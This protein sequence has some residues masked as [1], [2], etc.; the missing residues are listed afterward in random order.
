MNWLARLLWHTLLSRLSAVFASLYRQV[1]L[2]VQG[3]KRKSDV[4]NTLRKEEQEQVRPALVNMT[5]KSDE[6]LMKAW[7][8]K[9]SCDNILDA[10]DN[11]KKQKM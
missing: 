5:R 7:V 2:N 10:N 1:E 4:L 8:I 9:Q 6:T 3:L 11:M